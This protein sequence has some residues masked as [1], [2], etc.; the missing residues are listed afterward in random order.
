MARLTVMVAAALVAAAGLVAPG[1]AQAAQTTALTLTVPTTTVARGTPYAVSGTLLSGVSGSEP[2]VGVTV[3]LVRTDLAGSR[4]IYTKTTSEGFSISDPAAV[5]G[6]VTWKASWPGRLD[7]AAAV[8]TATVRVSRSSTSLSV[9]T[10]ASTYAYGATA[11]I[12][13][14]L[15]TTYSGRGV[16]LYA[17][18]LGTTIAAPG[19]L[20]KAATVDANGNLTAT[21]RM[22]RT[23]VF[24]ASFKGDER[25]A[26]A[27]ASSTPK[28]RSTITVAFDDAANVGKISGTTLSLSSVYNAGVD[29][30]V[31]APRP[32][33]CLGST[34]QVWSGSSWVTK[35]T[36]SCTSHLTG[37]STQAFTFEGS[38]RVNA[39]KAIRFL[40]RVTGTTYNSG[41]T[42]PWYY[43]R[44]Y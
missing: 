17:R 7:Q 38:Y 44:W 13:A 36:G 5:G 14:H 27:G 20:V 24:T 41:Y 42:S 23:T 10:D 21:Y 6:L 9:R 2:V 1:S 26:P 28:T 40:V 39:P 37:S 29:I 31:R 30:T 18:P 8:D 12:T 4:T 16:V 22:T 35:A 19:K 32:G 3:T 43:I 25:Y 34:Y 33:G 15:G 11:R